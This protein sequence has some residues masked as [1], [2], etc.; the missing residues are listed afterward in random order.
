M[1]KYNELIDKIIE[2]TKNNTL[3]WEKDTNVPNCVVFTAENVTKVFHTQINDKMSF[4]LIEFSYYAY[5]AEFDEKYIDYSIIGSFIQ[6]NIEIDSFGRGDL[7]TPFK[8][9]EL[10]E[11]VV[12]KY[13]NKEQ[14][15]DDFL[16]S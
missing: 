6:N 10:M 11:L 9:N 15:F 16:N 5:S 1:M 12:N 4:Y 2:K 13:F 14:Q 3:V 8:M 7:I